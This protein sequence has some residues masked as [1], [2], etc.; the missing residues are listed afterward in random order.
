MPAWGTQR[1]LVKQVEV[2]SGQ[3]NRA[4]VE[5]SKICTWCT[6]SKAQHIKAVSISDPEKAAEDEVIGGGQPT[7]DAQATVRFCL[8]R[9][10]NH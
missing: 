4:R 3:G 8:D 7:E 10:R 9:D 1:D 5:Q 2:R 6:Q